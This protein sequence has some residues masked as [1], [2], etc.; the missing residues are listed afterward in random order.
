MGGE[1][2]VVALRSAGARL[3]RAHAPQPLQAPQQLQAPQPL[4]ARQRGHSPRA[5]A[6]L[7]LLHGCKAPSLTG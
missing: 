3:A 4:Q 6:A 7:G 2:G 5:A 1:Q